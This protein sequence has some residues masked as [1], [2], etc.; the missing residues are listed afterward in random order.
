VRNLVELHGGRIEV[1]SE[2]DG[3]G[4]RFT[5]TLP[6][7]AR[8]L[9]APSGPPAVDERRMPREGLRVLVVEDE[10]DSLEMLTTFLAARGLTVTGAASVEEALVTWTRQPFDA[11]VSDLRMPGRDGYALVRE[12]RAR[13]DGKRVRA[14]AVSANAAAQDMQQSL[15]AGF[16]VHLAKPI[17]PEDLLTA[18]A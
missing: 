9:D 10:P 6:R 1:Y 18:L 3:R 7:S 11:L 15:L 2:G 8:A 14:V 13:D 5:V 16:D 12:I 17:D 4:S